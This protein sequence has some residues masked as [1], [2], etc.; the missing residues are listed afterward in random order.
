MICATILELSRSDIYDTL[1]CSVWNQVNEAKKILT[2]NKDRLELLTQALLE[3]ETLN[4][5]EF[6]SLMETGTLPETSSNDKPRT[7]AEILEQEAPK[8]EQKD[9][10]P[11]ETA[12]AEPAETAKATEA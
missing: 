4:R 11:A 1:S 7:T 10:E 2:E 3:Q 5:A 6:V 12:A 9:A 8:A